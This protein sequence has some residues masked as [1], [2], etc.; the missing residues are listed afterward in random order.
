VPTRETVLF[1]GNSSLY[2]LKKIV[3]N[4]GTV[5]VVVESLK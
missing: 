1:G 5:V 4:K 2:F 3:E